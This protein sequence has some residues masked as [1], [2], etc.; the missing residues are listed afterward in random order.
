MSATVAAAF[1]RPDD[2]WTIAT[3]AV[4]S[5]ACAI[6]G[7][8]LVLRRQSLLGDAISHAILPG[9]AGAF[10]LTGSRDPWWMLLGAGAVGL[11][12]AAL[13]GVLHR[14]GRVPPDAAM[15]VVF[16]VFFAL[17]VVLISLAAARVDLDPGCVLY[18][19]L[20]IVAFDTLSVAGVE[21]P[22]VLVT[23]SVVLLVNAALV[24]AFF[25]ELKVASFDPALATA[26]GFSAGLIHYALMT[27]TAATAVV[28]FEAVGS[29]LVVAM[30][31]APGATAHL[32]TDRL[33]RLVAIA[34]LSAGLSAFVGYLVALGLNTSVAGSVATIAGGQFLLA[35]LLAPRHGVGARAVARRLLSLRIDR[36]DVLGT[37]YRRH[38]SGAASGA[39]L[40]WAIP[41]PRRAARAV[42]ALR[43]RGLLERAD[44]L[45]LT[46]A[47]LDAAR[48]VVRTHRLWETFLSRELGLPLDHLHEASHRAEHFISP[49]IQRRLSADSPDTDPHGKRI[50]PREG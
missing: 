3:A 30:L 18:G 38:E 34:C 36:E 12:T 43:R 45:R 48:G 13:S 37:L 10:L 31:V 2:W 47:G 19:T 4:C 15:G 29:V 11:A 44:P 5:V 6:P 46:P 49:E 22:R 20:E 27:A 1:L 50:P 42:R 9:L 7:C 40:A 35:V 25:K 33:G 14:R 26:M 23:L 32:L 17:G 21:V 28:S 8:F 16:S 41:D 39:E 24:A